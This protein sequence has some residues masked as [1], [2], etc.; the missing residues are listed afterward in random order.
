MHST[1]MPCMLYVGTLKA[2]KPLTTSFLVCSNSIWVMFVY[3][4]CHEKD[5]VFKME[6]CWMSL[7]VTILHCLSHW[8]AP[9]VFFLSQGCPLR[10]ST[11]RG[12]VTQ[13][14]TRQDVGH[15][16]LS[17]I[18]T[19]RTACTLNNLN[20]TVESLYCIESNEVC[21]G[22]GNTKVLHSTF[23]TRLGFSNSCTHTTSGTTGVGKWYANKLKN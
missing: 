9:E 1:L 22:W 20:L 6:I 17:L 11:K 23:W 10:T 3:V 15:L 13:M 16:V 19:V 5:R 21:A 8:F 7:N 18:C 14:Q 12:E 2:N 4:K